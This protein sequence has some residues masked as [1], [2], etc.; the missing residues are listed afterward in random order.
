[1]VGRYTARPR[2]SQTSQ[3]CPHPKGKQNI[4]APKK[5]TMD[6]EKIIFLIDTIEENKSRYTQR[7]FENAKKA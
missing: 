3:Y 2:F 5:N 4:A 6:E 7:E 1:M